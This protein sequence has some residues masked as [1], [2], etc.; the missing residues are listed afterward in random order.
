MTVLLINAIL[1]SRSDSNLHFHPVMHLLEPNPITL[2][3]KV[4]QEKE[5][6]KHAPQAVISNETSLIIAKGRIL[7]VSIL[8]VAVMLRLPATG[9]C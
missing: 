7:H 3:N 8:S 1:H 2:Q 6:T 5:K 4:E 9:R